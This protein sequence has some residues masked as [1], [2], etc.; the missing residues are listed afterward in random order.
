M[1]FDDFEKQ[2]LNYIEVL[3]NLSC[4]VLQTSLNFYFIV[5]LIY[6]YFTLL[7]IKKSQITNLN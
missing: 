4:T 7:D 1:S 2:T 3:N 6:E 5:Y